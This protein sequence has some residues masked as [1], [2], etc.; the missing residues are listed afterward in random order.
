[1]TEIEKLILAALKFRD[2]Q[3]WTILNDAQIFAVQ[4]P[5]GEIVYCC[6]MGQAESIL[7]LGYIAERRDSPLTSRRWICQET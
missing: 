5:S 4:K 1:M 3:L 7:P 2:E 6:I